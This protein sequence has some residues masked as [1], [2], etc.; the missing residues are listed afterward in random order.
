MVQCNELFEELLQIQCKKFTQGIL[1]G[2][3]QAE[4]WDVF[5]QSRSRRSQCSGG[6][7]LDAED[8]PLAVSV[9]ADL[10]R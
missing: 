3:M 8:C 2:P 5:R 9:A 4:Y 1:S 7:H 10:A 6:A